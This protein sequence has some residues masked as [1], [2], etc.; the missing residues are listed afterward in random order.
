[1]LLLD[2]LADAE[3]F[4]LLVLEADE[5]GL[6]VAGDDQ[7]QIEIS[8]GVQK[9]DLLLGVV[10]EVEVVEL[11]VLEL[12]VL[13]A[14]LVDALGVGLPEYVL[15]EERDR[16]GD[17]VLQDERRRY[18]EV[19]HGD[20][21]SL[22]GVEVHVAADAVDVRVQDQEDPVVV[23]LDVGVLLEHFRIKQNGLLLEVLVHLL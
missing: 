16:G 21:L 12:P 5:A 9:E 20:E 17:Q 6:L 15:E 3:V 4:V 22:L 13:L 23:A 19:A 14:A 10:L 11:W 18:R 7:G 2:V 1:M 8:E